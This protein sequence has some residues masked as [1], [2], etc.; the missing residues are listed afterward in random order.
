ML[1]DASPL[2][3]W[4]NPGEAITWYTQKGWRVDKAGEELLRNLN[5]PTPELL[6][7]IAPLRAAYRA[8]WEDYMING[9]RYGLPPD[10][11]S[12]RSTAPGN[13]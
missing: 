9:R 10:V 6:A 2:Q 7:L 11:R 1:L 3:V 4:A 5:K 13:G 8:R 12:P